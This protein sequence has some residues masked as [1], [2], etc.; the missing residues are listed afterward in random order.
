[1]QALAFV[2]RREG[3]R[4]MPADRWAHVMSLE[5]GW[6]PPGDA[7]RYVA[8]AGEAG[9]LEPGPEGEE[10]SFDPGPVEIPRGFRPRGDFAHEE[11]AAPPEAHGFLAW[12]DRVA[13]ASGSSRQAVLDEVAETQDAFG[14]LLTA[15]AAVLWL[16]RERG[17]DVAEEA[18]RE[19]DRLTGGA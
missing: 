16:A 13:E 8:Q 19:A 9:L 10:L 4:A 17:L 11:D 3:R 1:M 12:V 14:G 6:M 2:A 7:K 5:L 15:E 18:R